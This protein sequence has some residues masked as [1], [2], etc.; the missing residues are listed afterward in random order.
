MAKQ[1][2]RIKPKPQPLSPEQKVLGILT[3]CAALSLV[4]AQGLAGQLSE[5]EK[6]Q[7]VAMH[8]RL[9]KP[10]ADPLGAELAE[11]LRNV[12][13]RVEAER[14]EAEGTEGNEDDTELDA[15]A[16]E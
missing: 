3:R 12:G 2:K 15:A 4:S 7:L 5:G 16:G 13:D 11:L 14:A 6:C 9:E 10:A 1:P 8:D